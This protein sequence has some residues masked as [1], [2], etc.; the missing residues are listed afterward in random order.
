[1]NHD[2]E[3]VREISITPLIQFI[4]PYCRM[5]L[6]IYRSGSVLVQVMACCLMAPRHC[7]DQFWLTQTLAQYWSSHGVH[8]I[9]DYSCGI[10]L[11]IYIHCGIHINSSPLVPNICVIYASM[12]P[13]SISSDNGL[14]PIR[15]QAII[16]TNAGLLSNRTLMNKF[17]WNLLKNQTFSFRKMHLKMWFCPGENE[18]IQLSMANIG[19]ATLRN[20]SLFHSMTK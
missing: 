19:Y 18:L 5:P 3:D 6:L 8:C 14:P 11:S 1:M 7:L 16:Y 13:V 20:D 10:Q 17:Q 12:N 4:L 2:G 15:C 9:A